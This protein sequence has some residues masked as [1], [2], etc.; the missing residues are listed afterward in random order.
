MKEY[1]LY[2]KIKELHDNDKEIRQAENHRANVTTSN[3][4]NI[5]DNE[6]G[7]NKELAQMDVQL[8]TLHSI[9]KELLTQISILA[10]VESEKIN[11]ELCSN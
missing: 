10:K 5:F 8:T 11:S 1:N 2:D 7:R 6:M 4:Y 9:R 3:F